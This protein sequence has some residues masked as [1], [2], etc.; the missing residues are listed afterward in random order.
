MAKIQVHAPQMSKSW[1]WWHHANSYFEKWSSEVTQTISWHN[2]RRCTD[3]KKFCWCHKDDRI[4]G[5]NDQNLEYNR[6]HHAKKDGI[7]ELETND[8]LL[9]QRKLLTSIVEELT[10][11]VEIAKVRFEK[12]LLDLGSSNNFIYLE[13]VKDKDTIQPTSR[14]L[15]FVD[16]RTYPN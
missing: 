5:S 3:V 14:I 13:H 10:K 1:I 15:H 4:H 6:D 12:A 2:S 16:N 9:A 8:A 11:P 7:F